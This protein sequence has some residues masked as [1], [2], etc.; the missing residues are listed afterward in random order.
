MLRDLRRTAAAKNFEDIT[1][2]DW[3]DCDLNPTARGAEASQETPPSRID[4]THPDL[5]DEQV[6]QAHAD[7]APQDEQPTSAE[8]STVE[9]GTSTL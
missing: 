4:W 2:Q 8:Q 6:T 9:M 3:P 1:E 7:A 5:R